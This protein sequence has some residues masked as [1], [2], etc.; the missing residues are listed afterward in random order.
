M[1]CKI[2]NLIV[3]ADNFANLNTIVFLVS[4]EKLLKCSEVL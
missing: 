1:Q 4:Y 2:K 3:F